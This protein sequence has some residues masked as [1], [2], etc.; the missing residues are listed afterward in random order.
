MDLNEA[1]ERIFKYHWVLILLLTILG[2]SIPLGLAQLQDD[3]YVASARISMGADDA[4]DGGEANS[5]ADTALGIATSPGVLGKALETAGVQRDQAELATL[6]QVD[7]V[8]TSGI[9]QLSVTDAD[10]EASAAIAT[11]LATEVVARR[12]QA[13]LGNTE[14][15]L[16][17]TDVQIGALRFDIMR[18]EGEADAAARE[19]GR[20][21][22]IGLTP[23]GALDVIRLRYGQA[24]E[25]LTRLET[26]RDQLA[27]T[28]AQAVRPEVV[29]STA[30]GIP[31]ESLLPARLAV[32]ALL[33][34]LLGV[35]IAATLEAWRPT[36]SPTSL[37]RHLGVPLLGNL[38]RLPER[39]GD[40]S[41]KWIA[42]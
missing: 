23:G 22:G 12:T 20:L 24:V 26:Q 15:L 34:L 9:L 35:A 5:L 17:Q 11:A 37:A 38:R 6:V 3:A 32:G 16:A 7:P 4:R 30:R 25:Q 31:V 18:L 2:L 41:D 27:Q 28:L 39:A 10:P 21:R 13:V 14:Q 42:S 29:A 40:L 19:E 36:L 8:G 1:A 33:G